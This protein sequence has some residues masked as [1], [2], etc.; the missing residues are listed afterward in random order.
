[1]SKVFYDQFLNLDKI[2]KRIKKLVKDN[3]ELVEFSK[4]IDKIIHYRIFESI[5]KVLPKEHHQEFALLVS[6]NPADDKI[7]DFLKSK[8]E[9]DIVKIIKE[10]VLVLTLEITSVFS[11]FISKKKI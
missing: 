3:D 7:V 6:K 2:E 9:Q 5:L 8:I 11:S 1:M 10:T 4:E